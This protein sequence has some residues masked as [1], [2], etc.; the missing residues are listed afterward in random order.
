M[1]EIYMLS[2][3]DNSKSY[4]GMTSRKAYGNGTLIKR[5]KKKHGDGGFVSMILRN[6]RNLVTKLGSVIP[7]SIKT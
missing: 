4:V 3:I 5:A 6:S 1:I 2:R 7:K